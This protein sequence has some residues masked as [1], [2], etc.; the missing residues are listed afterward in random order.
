LIA[1]GAGLRPEPHKILSSQRGSG[2][3]FC[4][5]NR[6]TATYPENSY[7]ILFALSTLAAAAFLREQDIRQLEN[8]MRFYSSIIQSMSDGVVT[9]TVNGEMMTSNAS[10][11]RIL[12]MT[13]DQFLKGESGR[14]IHEDSTDFA[15]ED[16]PAMVN[17]TNRCAAGRGSG[18][19]L[20]TDFLAQKWSRRF[21]NLSFLRSVTGSLVNLFRRSPTIFGHRWRLFPI[22][23]I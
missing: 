20:R 17:L 1:P 15:S 12:R 6:G 5:R 4:Y 11:D 13:P 7:I 18:A 21:W 14:P 16:F 2:D 10:A 8:N 9:R 3:C 19:Y 22:T 23:P